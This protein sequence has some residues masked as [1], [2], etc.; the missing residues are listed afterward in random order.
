MK[1]TPAVFNDGA[2]SMSTLRQLGDVARYASR[3]AE[4]RSAVVMIRKEAPRPAPLFLGE[5][6]GRLQS[7]RKSR[8]TTAM[9]FRLLAYERANVTSDVQF[10]SSTEWNASLLLAMR[11]ASS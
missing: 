3:L 10:L 8:A 11:L 7:S 6:S 2:W 4:R 5:L 9:R 1:S